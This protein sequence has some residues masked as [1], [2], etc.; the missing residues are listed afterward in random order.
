MA[1]GIIR[2]SDQ[3]VASPITPADTL[4]LWV[5]D[6][7][8]TGVVDDPGYAGHI[9]I[10]VRGADIFE[11]RAN[12]TRTDQN[13]RQL[14]EQPS[15]NMR[16][17]LD[18]ASTFQL[19]KVLPTALG[20][21]MPLTINHRTEGSD[22]FFAS[23]SD[24]R[25]DGI[26]GL[27]TPHT[28]ATTYSVQ[29]RRATPL[30]N[31]PYGIL[32][33]NV[34]LS[35]TY[36]SSGSRSEY[37]RGGAN[38]FTLGV[39]YNIAADTH[40]VRLP[41]WLD[42]AVGL[43]PNWLL[44]T[45]P[46]A[47]FRRAEYRYSPRQFSFSSAFAHA[48][49]QRTSFTKPAASV[50]DTGR[51]V[52][53]EH[54]VWENRAAIDLQPLHSLNLRWDVASLRDLRDYG[55]TTEA[56]RAATFARRNLL[57]QDLG[58]ER[59]RTM[60]GLIEFSPRI[61]R[62]LSPSISFGSQFTMTR[63]PNARSLVQAGP[64]TDDTRL[65][66]RI[67]SAQVF[68]AGAA[69]NLET[70]LDAYLGRLPSI[71]AL[72]R[73][74]LPVDIRYS[75]TLASSLDRAAAM[76]GLGFQFALGS[77][78]DFRRQ[79]GRLA[80][81]AALSNAL[82]VS[83]SFRLPGELTLTN[84]YQRTDT[85]NWTRRQEDQHSVTDGWLRIFPD[86]SLNGTWRA[87]PSLAR[88]LSSIGGSAGFTRTN[89]S[90]F[91]LS[92]TTGAEPDRSGQRVRSFPVSI[93]ADWSVLGGFST[94]AGYNLST[95]TDRRPGSITDVTS[96]SY[97]GGITKTFAPR[98]ALK[99]PGDIRTHISFSRQDTDGHVRSLATENSSR[100]TDNGKYEFSLSGDTEVS[101]TMSFELTGSRIVNFD[102]NFNR[103]NVL[104]VFS[105]VMNLQFGRF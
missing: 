41:G 42:R 72:S 74:I 93:A 99:L 70:V 91:A 83:G 73:R 82:A 3:P 2:V 46:L 71:T 65:P 17:S 57:G 40:S 69:L 56:A 85:R 25:A 13:F 67:N 37:Q 79:D 53:G 15:F 58:L 19:G 4:E 78:D 12:A 54:H 47:A 95:S 18:V 104:T 68:S 24:V 52:T 48:T 9:G 21:A 35:S 36:A 38:N 55:D 92:P 51:A 105:A 97:A 98:P 64:G 96:R 28:S 77:V 22:P 5:D 90:S 32:F 61:I 6:I 33:N 60:H 63:D 16:T 39:D 86:V 7:R 50:T 45:A 23:G 94:T 102:E 59:E 49:N 30:E 10:D 62:W 66:R 76:P 8:L 11:F 81:S 1:V 100:L 89:R 80:S 101:E 84:R 27:R 87:P 20:V 88:V 44:E 103:R 75:R 29:L 14:G 43:L 26:A 31:S 34:G